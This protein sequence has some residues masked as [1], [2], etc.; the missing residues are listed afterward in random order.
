MMCA[1]AHAHVHY[2]AIYSNQIKFTWIFTTHFHRMCC[3]HNTHV[4]V[5]FSSSTRWKEKMKQIQKYW[6]IVFQPHTHTNNPNINFTLLITKFM[7]KNR[8]TNKWGC[9]APHIFSIT[10][11]TVDCNFFNKIF[12][13]CFHHFGA[14]T[15]NGHKSFYK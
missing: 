11:C 3:T 7:G 10:L 12:F 4:R 5:L 9:L 14:H 13:I 8:P 6:W 15:K 1:P 2:H